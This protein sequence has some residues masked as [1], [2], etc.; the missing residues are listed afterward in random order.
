MLPRWICYGHKHTQQGVPIT[1]RNPSFERGVLQLSEVQ[2]QPGGRG[3][4]LGAV[5]R[6]GCQRWR[7]LL[8]LGEAVPG[9]PPRIDAVCVAPCGLEEGSEVSL[10]QGFGLILG[11]PV[12]FRFFASSTRQGDTLAYRLVRGSGEQPVELTPKKA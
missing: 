7:C 11:E 9:L 3:H 2:V 12:S 10:E 5:R 1:T 8:A 4:D 6:I